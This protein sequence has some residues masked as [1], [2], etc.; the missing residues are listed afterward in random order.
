MGTS[1]LEYHINVAE[2][3]DDIAHRGSR[4]FYSEDRAVAFYHRKLARQ[5]RMGDTDDVFARL[6]AGKLDEIVTSLDL[7]SDEDRL[8]SSEQSEIEETKELIQKRR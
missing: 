2:K 3:R 6:P 4:D 1:K 5:I 7:L 8:F